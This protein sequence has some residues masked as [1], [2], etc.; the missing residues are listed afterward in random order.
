MKKIILENLM[1]KCENTKQILIELGWCLHKTSYI[2]LEKLMEKNNLKDLYLDFKINSKKLR[3]KKVIEVLSKQFIEE[4]SFI[5][6][7]KKDRGTIKR[8]IIKNKLL[9]YICS[10]CGLNS[11]WNNK[12]LVLQLDHINGINN[13]NRLENLRFLCPNCHS[14]TNTHS[15]KNKCNRCIDCDKK[16]TSKSNRCLEC[17]AKQMPKKFIITKEELKKLLED[18]KSFIQI[19]KMF[20]VSNTTVKRRAKKLNLI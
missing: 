17:N 9:P 18:K 15:G 13:D 19:G 2:R 5:E 11:S 8:Y 4:D 7:S 10:E 1:Q 14:Q 16:I 6:N 20:N 12:P 3:T